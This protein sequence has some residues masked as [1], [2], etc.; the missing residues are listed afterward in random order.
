[1]FSTIIGL[2]LIGNIYI[3][4]RGLKAIASYSVGIKVLLSILYW[5]GA[6]A[7]F[8]V[9]TLRRTDFSLS[10]FSFIY[11]IGSGWL[12]F[13]LYMVLCLLVFDII[14][15]FAR[16]P[17]PYNF[18]LSIGITLCVLGYGYYNYQHP[19]TKVLNLAINKKA[20]VSSLK[21]V[22]FSDVHMGLGTGKKMI[23]RYVELVNAQQPDLILI[24][25]DLI[26]NDISPVI[27]ERMDEELS[28]LKAPL[29]IYMVPGNHDYF[30]GIENIRDFL[31]KTPIRLLCDSVVTLPNGIQIIGR[32]DRRSRNRLPL[33]KL[34]IQTEASLPIILL[35]HQPYDLDVTAAQGIDLQFSGHTHRGQ[36]WPMSFFIGRMFELSY[37]YEKRKD[38]HFYVTS[39]ISLWGPPFR[40]GTNSEIVVFNLTFTN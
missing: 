40:I 12:I 16:R 9:Y 18:V 11:E 36:V 30:D 4:F 34:S 14:R 19:K 15:L 39:G 3:F 31:G 29:G 10:V 21:V 27:K 20:S 5:C 1:M 25:G 23:E 7:L 13:T 6:S 33:E 32:D 17:I 22:G 2:Y 24:S 38:T 26:D 28:R 35:D 8:I 37:G